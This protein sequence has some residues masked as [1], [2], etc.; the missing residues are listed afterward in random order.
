M[1]ACAASDGQDWST[2]AI[3]HYRAGRFAEAE[4][5]YRHALEVYD[6]TGQGG[7]LARALALENIAV[8]LR[9]QGRYAD[10]V[11]LHLEALPRIEELAGA[12]SVEAARAG[13]NLAALYWSMGRLDL[14]EPLAT[15]AEASF[16][17]MQG[18]IPD[19]EANRRFWPRFT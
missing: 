4:T 7:T 8:M 5:A 17:A 12:Q 13:S 10:S 3:Q 18:T 6:R 9:A 11:T 16:E 2:K 19:R 1:L 15:R 14:A